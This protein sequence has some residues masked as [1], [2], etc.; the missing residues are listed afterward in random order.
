MSIQ[1][2][3][4]I[5]IR[6]TPVRSSLIYRA[7]LPVNL[8]MISSTWETKY[9]P[10]LQ[11]EPIRRGTRIVLSRGWRDGGNVQSPSVIT[12]SYTSFKF[13]TWY[14]ITNTVPGY[15]I[16]VSCIKAIKSTYEACKG[17]KTVRK[18]GMNEYLEAEKEA[19]TYAAAE[20]VI[21]TTEGR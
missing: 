18:K 13:C 4:L 3:Y 17:S 14:I 2:G 15:E 9:R 7:D 19:G 21:E 6:V 5:F 8:G 16:N 10:S 12:S 1:P 11:R 20:R